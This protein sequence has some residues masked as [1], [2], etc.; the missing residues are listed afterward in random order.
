ML[1]HRDDWTL[2]S[3]A[4][5]EMERDTT[6]KSGSSEEELGI[7]TTTHVVQQMTSHTS[8]RA[9][10]SEQ[11]PVLCQPVEMEEETHEIH[12]FTFSR[13]DLAEVRTRSESAG[14]GGAS[15]GSCN[16]IIYFQ[17]KYVA[18]LQHIHALLLRI[19]ITLY[20]GTGRVFNTSSVALMRQDTA[21]TP[22]DVGVSRSFKECSQDAGSKTSEPGHRGFVGNA[23]GKAWRLGRTQ[24]P[25]HG[26]WSLVANT[27]RRDSKLNRQHP[28]QRSDSSASAVWK[29]AQHC[30]RWRP[31]SW[32]ILEGQPMRP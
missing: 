14:G 16:G 13:Y 3:C 19:H 28:L 1:R 30:S 22:G 31:C 24:D 27:T 8:D 32:S 20:F 25:C 15:W 2:G 17:P 7:C 5:G 23:C 18:S 29:W 10:Q 9:Q 26:G 6:T 11:H 21:T 12:P 4:D